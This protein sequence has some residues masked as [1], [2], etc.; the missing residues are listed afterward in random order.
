MLGKLQKTSTRVGSCNYTFKLPMDKLS[1]QTNT[2]AKIG[3]LHLRVIVIVEI[4]DLQMIKI[5]PSNL[6]H[7]YDCSI[8]KT[9]KA[10]ESNFNF[11]Q[12]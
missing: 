8:V 11:V 2:N 10:W 1:F 6:Y 9:M 5:E 7:C 3:H 12:V 4:V